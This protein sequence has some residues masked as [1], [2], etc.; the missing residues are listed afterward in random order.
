[1]KW[2]LCL[3]LSLSACAVARAELAVGLMPASNSIPIVV[4]AADGLYTSEGVEVR[5]VPFSGQLERETALQT[6]A[7]GFP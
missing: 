3:V 7:I 5:L 1:M 2:A 6:G 4:A